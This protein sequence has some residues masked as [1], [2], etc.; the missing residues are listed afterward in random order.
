MT[1]TSF[2]IA[3]VATLC[4]ANTVE[5]EEIVGVPR[6]GTGRSLDVAGQHII[7][8]GLDAPDLHQTCA[9][10]DGEEFKCGEVARSV[11]AEVIN[12]GKVAC[13]VEDSTTDGDIVGTC[14][15][16]A[17]RS[18]SGRGEI[19]LGGEMVRRGW[20]VA[21]Y[22][23]RT[24]EKAPEACPPSDRQG[25][26]KVSDDRYLHD[27]ADAVK[28]RRGLWNTIFDLPWVW[29]RGQSR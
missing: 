16:W 4:L 20:A 19:D 15:V 28:N 22:V 2:V 12:G 18:L 25:L 8:A 9:S 14:R 7:L 27:E 5:A 24:Q 6:I 26:C 29:R 3:V 23:K 11:L 1:K 17:E 13:V 21:R 10:A